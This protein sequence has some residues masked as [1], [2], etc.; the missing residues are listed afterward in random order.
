MNGPEGNAADTMRLPQA[1]PRA[2]HPS[3]S[4]MVTLQKR[5]DRDTARPTRLPASTWL[6]QGKYCE[7]AGEEAKIQDSTKRNKST[8]IS[9]PQITGP[10]KE[11]ECVKTHP[12]STLRISKKREG[13]MTRVGEEEEQ[14]RG[15]MLAFA[16]KQEQNNRTQ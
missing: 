12:S 15:T 2:E 10:C 7:R 5:S 8:N 9:L 6:V 11:K 1:R 4:F 13:T 3:D 16:E 14:Q